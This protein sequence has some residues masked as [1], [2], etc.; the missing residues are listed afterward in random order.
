MSV[1][2]QTKLQKIEI[3]LPNGFERVSYGITAR[4]QILV[5]IIQ[6]LNKN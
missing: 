3:A 5:L 4:R 1:P 6:T 2:I